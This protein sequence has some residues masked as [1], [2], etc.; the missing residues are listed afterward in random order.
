M[1][2]EVNEVLD[3]MSTVYPSWESHNAHLRIKSSEK[4]FYKETILH[5]LI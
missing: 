4:V 5:P 3:T 1:D 2:I